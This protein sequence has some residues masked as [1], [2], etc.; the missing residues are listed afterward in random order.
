MS[1]SPVT[2]TPEA[3]DQ[4]DGT[5]SA[6]GVAA[7]VEKAWVRPVAITIFCFA[8]AVV[9]AL[10]LRY[11]RK[12]NSLEAPPGSPQVGIALF[13]GAI[14]LM[15]LFVAVFRP[16]RGTLRAL[17]S[18]SV[19]WSLTMLLGLVLA[20]TAIATFER[21]DAWHGTPVLNTA[22]VNTYL[23]QHVPEGVKP[24][25]I[26]T[27]VLI[28]SLEFLNGDNV[29][30]TGFIWQKY[31]PEIPDDLVRGVVLAEGIKDPY[32]ETVA[33]TYEEDGVETVG[34]YFETV[35]RQPFQYAE[36][37]FDEQDVWLRLW[38]KDFA[39]DTILVPDFSSYVTLDPKALPGLEKEFVYSGWSP[40]YSGFTLS[41]QPYSTSFGIGKANQY[42]GLPE[43]YFN[44][45]L[46]RNFAGPFFEHVVFAIAVL[47]ML[48]G[49]LALTTND[50]NLKARFQLSTAGV[51]TASSGLLFAVILKHNQ[52]RSVVGP[53]GISYIEVIPILL[54]GAIIVVVLNAI[55]LSSPYNVKV[56]HR[57]NNLWPVLAY[58]PAVL[59]ILFLVTLIVFFKP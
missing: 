54:Y 23:A 27:G 8:M 31:G 52:L 29:Q 5:V 6:A 10:V 36:F 50:E 17:V 15:A 11:L 49:L 45:V 58:W 30:V 7:P 28:K 51:L 32:K 38:A 22:D 25:L 47:F 21:Q 40:I 14:G 35:V 18:T 4:D 1:V 13:V 56:I 55:L 44:L 48:F 12:E 43:M 16:E 2:G 53:R 9:A 20:W 34:W 26:P 39:K 3:A 41:D 59:G 33:Y 57:R 37:P 24:I 42:A 46:D 19:S